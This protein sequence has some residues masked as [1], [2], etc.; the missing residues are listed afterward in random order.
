MLQIDIIVLICILEEFIS[1][2]ALGID[3]KR[4]ASGIAIPVHGKSFLLQIVQD[5]ESFFP[6]GILTIS[7]KDVCTHGVISNDV[8]LD[9]FGSPPSSDSVE[10]QTV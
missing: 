9:I 8:Y 3:D 5:V 2:S 10:G 6:V 7:E 4:F 1:K